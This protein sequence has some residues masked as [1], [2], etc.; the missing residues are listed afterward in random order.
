MPV[1]FVLLVLALCAV[2]LPPL[3][4]TWGARMVE[5]PAWPLAYA[6]AVAA[7]TMQDVV[8]PP[9]LAALAA[10]IGLALAVATSRRRAVRTVAW[11]LL[12]LLA[13]AL[14]MHRVPGFHNPLSLDAVTVSPGARP[15]TQYLNF[16]K[17]S[18]GLVLLALLAP[19]WRRHDAASRTLRMTLLAFSATCAAVFGLALAAGWLRVDP[20]LPTFTALF[21]AT[22]LFF[23]CI[24]EEAFFRAVVQDGLR[25]RCTR[26]QAA[27]PRWTLRAGLAIGV[28]ALLFGLAHAGSGPA[29][30]SLATLTGLG[31]ATAYAATN[32]IEAPI[33]VHFGVNALHFLL[34]TY[35]A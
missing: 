27:A 29:M 10:L 31:C 6:A 16:D 24:A 7:A 9:G 4:V 1:T 12:A 34:F 2:W 11:A 14:A 26:E 22:N 32:R 8:Q 15:F 17:A 19:R 13:L 20:K 21:L 28:S 18:A 30:V 35:P 3:R 25:G 5:W 33:A 23:T